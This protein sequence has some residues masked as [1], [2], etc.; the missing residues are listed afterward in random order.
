MTWKE[1]RGKARWSSSTLLDVENSLDY[2][3]GAEEAP[4]KIAKLSVDIFRAV[5]ELW[6]DLEKKGEEEEQ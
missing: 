4:E 1:V 6:N 3:P 2:K 5:E